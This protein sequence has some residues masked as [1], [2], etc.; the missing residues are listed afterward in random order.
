M[1]VNSTA[2]QLIRKPGKFVELLSINHIRIS[3]DRHLVEAE[4]QDGERIHQVY[5]KSLDTTLSPNPEAFITSAIIPCMKKRIPL[6]IDGDVDASYLENILMAETTLNS[7]K[8]KYKK[9]DILGA[10]P[11]KG[12]ALP[13]QRVGVFFSGGID[14]FFTFLKNRDEITD[15]IFV[16]GFDIPLEQL[17]MRERMSAMLKKVG[18]HFGKR[19][20]EVETNV[21]NFLD[22]YAF[23]GF[24]HGAVLGSIG[25]LLAPEFRRIYIA[26]ART[27]DTLR[28]YGVHPDLDPYWGKNGLE[29]IHDGLETFRTQKVAFISQY[30]VVLESLRICLWFPREA[31]NC[32]KCEKCLRGMVYLR[33]FGA[34]ERCTT[35]ETP[36]N[37]NRLTRL[38]I[39]HDPS[40][41]ALSEVLSIVEARGDDPELVEAVRKTIYRPTW[42]K[43]LITR[44]RGLRKKIHLGLR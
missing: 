37:L 23:W 19:V 16:H 35:F 31:L 21:R 7:W 3:D 34:L 11:I 40:G 2:T 28:P 30:D 18:E 4:L 43:I 10:R 42:Q 13:G 12:S 26:A 8:P 20:I 5:F 15:L 17:S 29:Y 14:S 44:F 33:A 32:G 6:R 24:T 38:K 9:V 39:T 41:D 36:L 25:H 27:Y 22:E 1:W